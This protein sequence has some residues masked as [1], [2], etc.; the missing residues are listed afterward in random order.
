MEGWFLEVGAVDPETFVLAGT[1]DARY[2]KHFASWWPRREDENVLLLCFEH[3]KAD[4]E[5][6][7]RQIAEFAGIALD[8]EL[9]AITLEHSSLA[10]MQAHKDRFDD[11]ML[12]ARSEEEVLPPGSDSAKVRAGQVGE[13]EFSEEVKRRFESLWT[14]HLLPVT[15]Y[16]AYDDLIADLKP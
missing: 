13:F 4:H 7:I 1:K 5:G 2:F 10:F 3:M 11:A 15:G 14:E 8:D 12:R 9:L 16:Q 6:T